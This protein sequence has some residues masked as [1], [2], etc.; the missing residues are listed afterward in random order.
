MRILHTADWHM[1]DRLGRQDR[2]DDIC[3]ALEQIAAYLEEYAVDVML[4]AGDLFSEH[5]RSE[6]MRTAIAAIKRIFLPFIERGGT[7]IA[8]SGNHDNEIF[9]D[10]LRDALDLVTPRRSQTGD[11]HPTGQLY[12]TSRP[13]LLKLAGAD[14]MIVQFVL[15]PYPTPRYYLNN[16]RASYQ[17]IECKHRTIQGAFDK[18]FDDFQRKLDV[19]LPSV[20]MSHIHIRGAHIH[21]RYQPGEED[22]I[23]VEASSIPAHLAYVAYGHIHLPQSALN[24]AA[25][26]RY[27]GSIERMDIGEAK[28]TK[29]VVLCDIGVEGLIGEPSLLPLDSTPIYHVEITDPDNQLAQLAANYPDADRALV[30][31]T[32]HWDPLKHNR[33]DL[34]RTIEAI[35]PRWYEHSFQEIGQ[36]EAQKT[37]FSQQNILDV[38]GTVRDYLTANLVNDPDQ[39]LLLTLAN[40]LL[41]QEVWK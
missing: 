20:L 17:S 23:I 32:L 18:V 41:A 26:I 25:H 21:S 28:D 29:S 15:M 16:A 12:I 1:Q 24:G 7:I 11:T 10:T 31:Y 8:I 13:R 3:R 4:V 6:Q 40:E 33:E 37:M 36:N 14:G 2:S 38:V 22:T 34:C 30:K 27:S 9:F 39:E 19:R 35:F 5:C